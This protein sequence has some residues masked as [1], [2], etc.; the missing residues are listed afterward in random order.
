MGGHAWQGECVWQGAC[1]GGACMARET[2]IA[3]GGTASYWSAF[4]YK[5][6][7]ELVL[8]QIHVSTTKMNV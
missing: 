1:M 8:Q 3:P 4:L 7:K 5:V 2:A 6:I